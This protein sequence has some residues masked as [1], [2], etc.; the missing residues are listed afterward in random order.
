MEYVAAHLSKDRDIEIRAGDM[1]AVSA[2][3]GGGFGSPVARD[4]AARRRD[5][6]L[7]YYSVEESQRL[8]PT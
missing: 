5:I 3:G 1:I 8:F 2:P 7:G 4:A 6:A